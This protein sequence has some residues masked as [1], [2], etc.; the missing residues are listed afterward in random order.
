MSSL[1]K[2]WSS[3]FIRSTCRK[4]QSGPR[5]EVQEKLDRDEPASKQPGEQVILQA[6]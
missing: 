3:I 6:I 4:S 1:S 2:E 5:D